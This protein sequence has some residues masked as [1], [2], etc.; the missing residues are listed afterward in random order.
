MVDNQPTN[1]RN[2]QKKDAQRKSDQILFHRWR[3][4]HKKTLIFY[5][6]RETRNTKGDNKE[7]KNLPFVR[8][9]YDAFERAEGI[10]V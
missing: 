2:R 8:G 1:P 9:I 6:D 5:L 4:E 10:D 3:K 7:S